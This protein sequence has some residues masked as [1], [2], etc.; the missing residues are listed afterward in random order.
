MYFLMRFMNIGEV[1]EQKVAYAVLT[2]KERLT[3]GTFL[4]AT[5]T[6]IMS[7]V[8]NSMAAVVMDW[9]SAD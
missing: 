8:L 3:E 9:A 2:E 4:N 7:R 1:C 5:T 6:G